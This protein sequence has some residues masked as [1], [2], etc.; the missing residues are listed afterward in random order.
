MILEFS[1]LNVELKLNN[2]YLLYKI[3][4]IGLF[5]KLENLNLKVKNISE[6]EDESEG[7]NS[8]D[9]KMIDKK[10]KQI[11]YLSIAILIIGLIFLATAIMF[12]VSFFLIPIGL[13]GLVKYKSYNGENRRIIYYLLIAASL[14]ILIVTSWYIIMFISLNSLMSVPLFLLPF[15]PS[16]ICFIFG[17]YKLILERRTKVS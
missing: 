1:A 6:K 3:I 9:T 13:Y 11:Y 17:I 15:I 12:Y 14:P 16:L 10:S 2:F 8:D 5:T 7:M 4:I